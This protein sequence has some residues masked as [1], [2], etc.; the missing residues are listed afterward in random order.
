MIIM[1]NKN[2][3]MFLDE[4][5]IK[6][7]STNQ[8]FADWYFS[9]FEMIQKIISENIKASAWAF[10]GAEEVTFD[11]YEMFLENKYSCSSENLEELEIVA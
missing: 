5:T 10:A 8:Y 6:K 1:L 7:L 11:L 3:D 4:G 2:L 9:N